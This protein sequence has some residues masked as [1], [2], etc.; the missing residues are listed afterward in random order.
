[1]QRT[2][3]NRTLR[4]C[5]RNAGV[6]PTRPAMKKPLLLLLLAV[7]PAA[8]ALAQ[9]LE[10]SGR[11]APSLA[12]FAGAGTRAAAT[13]RG[14]FFDASPNGRT[15]NP[16][17]QRLGVGFGASVRAQHVGR[18]GLL[19]ALEGGYNQAASRA[20]VRT[21]DGTPLFYLGPAPLTEVAD[22]TT[23]LRMRAVPVFAGVG[24]RLGGTGA[25]QVDALVGPEWAVLLAAHEAGQGTHGGPFSP[26]GT[27][28]Q[29]D[30][31]HPL[32]RRH[33]WRLRADLTAWYRRLGLTASYA[34]GLTDLRDA[35]ADVPAYEV[36]GP[37]HSRT[38]RVGLAYRVR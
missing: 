15:N 11:A 21:Y 33:D 6:A 34:L 20:D 10:L 30:A 1:M 7:G 12:C 25:V 8:P 19:A 27:A 14:N 35:L 37:V 13:V 32:A 31:P 23:R 28:W 22:G 29:T 3:G 4:W 16:Y 18:R 38:L 2:R 36:P 5:V 9:H 17:G 26:A 24:Q